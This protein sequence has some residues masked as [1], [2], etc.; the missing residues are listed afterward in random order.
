ASAVAGFF[1]LVAASAGR[2]P[3]I[4]SASAAAS[5]FIEPPPLSLVSRLRPIG[6]LRYN[7]HRC[8]PWA[9]FSA[10][11]PAT[12]RPASARPPRRCWSAGG[13]TP[14]RCAARPT[15]A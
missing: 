15:P 14:S 10:S 6:E 5:F 8:P 1:F 3:I 2:L 11:A 13:A 4:T 9:P 12:P 7:H